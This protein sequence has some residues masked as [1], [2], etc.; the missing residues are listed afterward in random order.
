MG[1]K[2]VHSD[3]NAD[4]KPRVFVVAEEHVFNALIK[5]LAIDVYP[6]CF[7]YASFVQAFLTKSIST[8]NAIVLVSDSL[9][10]KVA[11][12]EALVALVRSNVLL[13]PWQASEETV[14]N[15]NVKITSR[16]P[17]LNTLR[18]SIFNHI[19]LEE[20][21][22]RYDGDINI[23]VPQSASVVDFT[24]TQKISDSMRDRQA[25]LGRMNSLQ[26]KLKTTKSIGAARTNKEQEVEHEVLNPTQTNIVTE[27]PL[28]EEELFTPQTQQLNNDEFKIPTQAEQVVLVE[29]V[30]QI[31]VEDIT[32]AEILT[33]T[34]PATAPALASK[35]L[36]T[37]SI[38]F[39]IVTRENVSNEEAFIDEQND[40]RRIRS[41]TSASSIIDEMD[42]KAKAKLGPVEKEVVQPTTF[43]KEFFE[44]SREVT[45]E[46]TE[47]AKSKFSLPE[48]PTFGN[49][50]PAKTANVNSS[51]TF[52]SAFDSPPKAVEPLF[53]FGTH[54]SNGNQSMWSMYDSKDNLADAKG[55]LNMNDFPT[56]SDDK[57]QL[58]IKEPMVI[59]VYSPK[60]GV[61]K[62]SI[63]VNLAARLSYTTRAQVCIVDLDIGFGNVGTR[64][65]LYNP[66]VRELLNENHLDSESLSRNLVYDRRSGLFALLAPLRPESGTNRR[67][68]S[69]A[70]YNK[71]LTLL[72]QR[73]DIVI[74]DCP[75]ELRD[76]LVSG[77]AL[78]SANKVVMV[79]N[80][81]QA[82]LLDARRALE[83]MCRSKESQRLPGLGIDPKS[84][85]LIV[86]QKVDNVGREVEDVLQVISGSD[87]NHPSNQVDLLAV[88]EDD[89]ELWV[90]NANM[91]RTVAT[92]GE[93][94]VDTQLD[95]IWGKLL[96]EEIISNFESMQN[97]D[98]QSS[99]KLD[100]IFSTHT[101]SNDGQKIRRKFH[102][103]RKKEKTNE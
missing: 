4:K 9:P 89:R 56:I 61:G 66:T 11:P 88:I 43:S 59:S 13:I 65:G 92:S 100:D 95:I 75:V 3:E 78:T 83:A 31:P 68:F 45:Q 33:P 28:V 1:L 26:D 35:P 85:G 87:P 71:I 77:F 51:S 102:L 63:S 37:S 72:T 79:V 19:G 60:G 74:L 97:N 10:E 29:P 15:L 73:F 99:S 53:A 62:T 40:T 90:G 46:K 84:I 8:N 57:K 5:D 18:R 86:N 76:P 22:T 44:Q 58:T 82:T 24:N 25:A 93:N 39:E 34:I 98:T 42:K 67:K 14:K 30:M 32:N 48:E 80:N 69:P 20:P 55:S 81:E 52:A 49:S 96:P 23:E 94:V 21:P 27:T 17:T 6:V 47:T 41:T 7:D 103:G 101:N 38:D 70:V 50:T 2:L 12:L 16:R 91:A 36:K 64:L 54:D